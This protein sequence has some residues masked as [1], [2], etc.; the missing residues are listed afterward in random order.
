L[1]YQTLRTF[2]RHGLDAQAGRFGEA[3]LVDAQIFLQELDQFAGLLAAGF[4]FDAGVDVFRVLAEDHHVGLLGF[5]DGRRNTLEVLDGTQ[6][7]VEV[8]LLTQCHVQGTD[9][10][11][12]GRGQRALDGYDVVAHRFEGF[13]RQPDVGA[14]DIGGLFP[15][16]DFH[17]VNLALAAVGLGNRSVHHLEHDRGN[18]YPSTVAL[19]IG[20]DGLV[21]Y[22]EREIG[23][24]RDLLAP[25]GNLDMLVGHECSRDRI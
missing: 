15:C 18:V 23:I 6:A 17:P 13:L 5:A 10:T 20:D 9:A 16:I 21:R 14:V 19:D 12:H 11:A 22:I 1:A 7:D 4:E 25:G 3:D 8:E 24:D 2:D